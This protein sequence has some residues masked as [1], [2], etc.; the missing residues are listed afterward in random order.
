MVYDSL[1]ESPF[2]ELKNPSF[3]KPVQLPSSGKA[4]HKLAG[5]QNVVLLENKRL[6]KSNKELI[7]C[8]QRIVK[9]CTEEFRIWH[10]R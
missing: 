6:T 1:T 10:K 7:L 5:F 4:A 8:G 3:R 9:F 2:L